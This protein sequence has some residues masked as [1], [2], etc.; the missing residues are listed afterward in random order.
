MSKALKNKTKL[1]DMVSVKDFGAIG[2]GVADDTAAIQAAINL[3]GSIYIPDGTYKITSDLL[4]K[5]NTQVTFGKNANFIAGANNLTFFKST[6]TTAAYFSQIHNAQLNGNGF[7]NVVGFD[8][9]NFRLNAGLFNPNMTDMLR[10]IIFRYGCFDTVIDNPTTF[11]NVSFPVTIM[12]NSGGVRIS[13]PNFDGTGLPSAGT[14]AIDIQ[15]GATIG[16]NIGCRIDGGYCQGFETGV[17]DRGLGTEINGTYFEQCVSTDIVAAGAENSVY[18]ATQHWAGIGNSAI[19]GIGSDSITIISP[20]MGSAQRSVG[21]LNFDNSNTNCMF[22]SP[23]SISFKNTPLGVIDGITFS[24]RDNSV[25]A[26]RVTAKQGCLTNS[27]STATVT[28]TPATIFA[29]SGSNRGRYDI[30]SLIADTASA[31]DYT[32]AATVIWDGSQARIIANNGAKLTTT[33]SGGNVQV[34]QTA[35]SNQ[36]VYW[37]YIYIPIV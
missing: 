9:Y 7:N 22:I 25:F 10:G 30:V 18:I 17:V 33:L 31:A 35:G 12:D 23:S 34:T 21:L 32:A 14:I 8:M 1:N 13:N 15:V 5:S 26:N 4:I 27:G 37:S 20:A 29:V 6:S 24:I 3:Q 16:K 2:D 11:D 28:A 19:Q 36:T